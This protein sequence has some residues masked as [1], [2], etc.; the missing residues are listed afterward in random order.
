MSAPGEHLV[1]LV[2]RAVR[3]HPAVARLDGG[4]DGTVVSE[5]PGGRVLGV[6]ADE[7]GHRVRIAVV[8]R[9]G[10]PLPQVV[11]ELRER[12]RALAGRV[13]V[14]VTI[15]GVAAPVDETDGTLS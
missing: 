2:A 1:E 4:P 5:L 13:P 11:D 15:S 10:H 9:W 6:R 8:V 12:V 14:D 3:E 7:P